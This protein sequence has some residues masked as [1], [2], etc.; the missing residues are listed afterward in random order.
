MNKPRLVSE[1]TIESLDFNSLAESEKLKLA[2]LEQDFWAYWIN[3][4]VSCNECWKVH[5][6]DAIY[7]N[8]S[9]YADIWDLKLQTVKV[10]ENVMQLDKIESPCCH[11]DT[12]PVY[13]IEENMK[14]ISHRLSRD[15]SYLTAYKVNGIIKGFL[16]GYMWKFSEIYKHEIEP[17]YKNVWELEIRRM[18]SKSI[19]KSV[20]KDVFT[21]SSVW[22]EEKYKSLYNIY[23]MFKHFIDSIEDKHLKQLF[24]VELDKNNPVFWIYYSLNVNTLD[25]DKTHQLDTVWTDYRSDLCYFNNIWEFKPHM[26]RDFRRFMVANKVKMR[27]AIFA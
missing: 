16:D 11:A 9:K 12:N 17:H 14:E 2:E 5:W 21:I 6:K 27:E 24:L 1:T 19:W 26:Q 10:I 8:E 20:P 15:A 4:Y 18:L 23:A 22:T 25:L 3:E 7:W 13:S